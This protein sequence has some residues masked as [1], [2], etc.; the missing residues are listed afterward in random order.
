MCEYRTE[1]EKVTMR[2]Q[3]VINEK[4][5]QEIVEASN[6]CGLSQSSFMKLAAQ[7]KINRMALQ[8][9]ADQSV[10]LEMSTPSNQ[11]KGVDAN[12]RIHTIV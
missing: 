10:S 12:E 8:A 1:D 2:L 11:V 5:R 7:E 4:K 6:K 3:I 9:K